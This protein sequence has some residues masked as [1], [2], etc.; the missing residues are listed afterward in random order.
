M[1]KKSDSG[2]RRIK[3]VDRSFKIIEC[4]QETGPATLSEVAEMVSL[5]PSTAHIY[6]STLVENEYVIKEDKEYRCSMQF[7]RTGGEIRDNSPLYQAAKNEIDDL[8]DQVSENANVGM[9]ENGYMVQLYKSVSPESIDDNAPLGA[10]LY[11]HSTATGKAI[12]SKLPEDEIDRIVSLRG[13]PKLTAATISTRKELAEELK[14]VREQGYAINN[15]EHF[16]GV[17]AVSVPIMSKD[18]SVIGSI[19]V[20]GPQSRISRD[21][22]ENALTEKLTDKANII[23]LKLSQH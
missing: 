4:L 20:S 7:L 21:R 16:P 18:G 23:E 1:A 22:I 19:S 17:R 2:G 11:L 8:R 13:L 3:S 14:R 15:G 10:H 9:I 6:L 12:L 5:P